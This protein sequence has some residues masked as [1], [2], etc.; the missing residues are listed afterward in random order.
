MPSLLLTVFVLQIVISVVNT[1]GVSTLNSLL[2]FLFTRIPTPTSKAVL[3]QRKLQRE[4]LR[5][6]AELNGISSQDQFA[7]WAKLRR[8]HDKTVADLEKTST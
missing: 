1:I 2:W 5:Q 6:R 8:Q 7:K 3:S 4:F